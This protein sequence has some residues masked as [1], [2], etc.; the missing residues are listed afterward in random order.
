MCRRRHLLSVFSLFFICLFGFVGCRKGVDVWPETGKKRVLVSFA[1]LYCFTKNVAGDDVDVRCLLTTQGPHD[2]SPSQHDVELANRADLILINGLGVDEWITAMA[3]KSKAS[4]KEIAE[5]I[6]NEHLRKMAQAEGQKDDD[7]GH[8]HGE[9]DPHVW[10]GP[11]Q[12][13]VM[14]EKIAAQLSAL[15]PAHKK[16]YEERAHGYIKELKELHAHGQ[17][18]FKDKKNKNLVAMHDSLGYFADAF[19]LKVV[20][21][22]QIRPGVETDAKTLTA[23]VE[24]CKEKGVRVIAVE[25]QYSK[26]SAEVL[27]KHLKKEGLMVELVEIDPLETAPV[28]DNNGNPDPAYYMKRMKQNI[29]DLA[30]ALP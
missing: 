2:F 25:P 5:E 30:K 1:P 11:A 26:Q 12:A 15:D 22:I 14:V 13:E 18:A 24:M 16:N 27:Q 7:H 3:K 23:L 29:D 28:A 8:K 4:I 21:S 20:G 19:G 6:P 17:A 9:H 10:L